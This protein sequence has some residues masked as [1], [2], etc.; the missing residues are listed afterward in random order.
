MD[1]SVGF[2]VVF[3]ALGELM[4]M[5]GETCK[6]KNR[7]YLGRWL[8]ENVS[9]EMVGNEYYEVREAIEK[10][11]VEPPPSIINIPTYQQLKPKSN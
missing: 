3:K 11:K 9:E 10:K 5:K 1:Q 7:K 8:E 2:E 6:K 4:V